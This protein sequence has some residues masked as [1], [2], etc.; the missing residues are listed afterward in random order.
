MLKFPK[1][2]VNLRRELI[3]PGKNKEEIL[4]IE[5]VLLRERRK[6]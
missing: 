4:E 1:I 3:F 5:K 6:T 2:F